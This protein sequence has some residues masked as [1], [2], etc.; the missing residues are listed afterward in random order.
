M[1]S[2]CGWLHR[3]SIRRLPTYPEIFRKRW[4]LDSI[5]VSRIIRILEIIQVCLISSAMK[6]KMKYFFIALLYCNLAVASS[7]RLHRRILPHLPQQPQQ[8]QPPQSSHGR[9]RR[10]MGI[11]SQ[12]FP[13]LDKRCKVFKY[14]TMRKRFCVTVRIYV[15][16]A[17]DWMLLC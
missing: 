14:G 4:S 17:L 15:C 2:L 8:P 6:T 16:K 7:F 3:T 10:S 11:R 5:I 9:Y 12:C 1:Y 13:R